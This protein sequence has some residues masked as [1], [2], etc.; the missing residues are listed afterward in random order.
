MYSRMIN[1]GGSSVPIATPA[2]PPIPISVNSSLSKIVTF[3]WPS[4]AISLAT[5]AS[6]DGVATF[7][8]ALPKSRAKHT[9]SP[10]AVPVKICS[11]SHP[12]TETVCKIHFLF[13]FFV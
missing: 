4:S 11:L 12:M 1:F 13:S 8:G 6:L 9:D 10:I 3:I 2:R 7:P 5:F